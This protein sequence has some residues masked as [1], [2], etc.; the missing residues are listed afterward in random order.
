MLPNVILS[1]L[2][3]KILQKV[4]AWVGLVVP[5]ETIISKVCPTQSPTRPGRLAKKRYGRLTRLLLSIVPTRIRNVLGQLPVD[6]G[7]S[8]MPKGK[9][10]G[11]LEYPKGLQARST[12]HDI[13]TH[14]I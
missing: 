1:C 11:L 6:W 14:W 12:E 7:Q 9:S 8:N 4:S 13:Q 10:W 5:V 3:L 2:Q